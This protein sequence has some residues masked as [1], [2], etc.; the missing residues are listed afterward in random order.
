[1]DGYVLGYFGGVIG[2]GEGEG[3]PSDEK[4]RSLR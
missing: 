4:R 1:M 3:R 2:G